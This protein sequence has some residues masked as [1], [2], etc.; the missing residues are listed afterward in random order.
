MPPSWRSLFGL[1]SNNFIYQDRVQWFV[2]IATIRAIQ[3]YH[4]FSMWR[5]WHFVW[6]FY[7]TFIICRYVVPRHQKKNISMIQCYPVQQKKCLKNACPAFLFKKLPVQFFNDTE[8]KIIIQLF[9]GYKDVKLRKL[10]LY[11][12]RNRNQITKPINDHVLNP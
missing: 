5:V 2:T 10:F 4:F 12:F 8:I 11:R 3:G 6:C 7:Y 1:D 9:L